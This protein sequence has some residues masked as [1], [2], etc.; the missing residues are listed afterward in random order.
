MARLAGLQLEQ[1]RGGWGTEPFTA[2]PGTFHI[3]VY[4]KPVA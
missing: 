3:S 4:R 2:L 1:R